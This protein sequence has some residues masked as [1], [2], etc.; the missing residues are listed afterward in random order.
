MI[1]Q[2]KDL[3]QSVSR[4]PW[5]VCLKQW[6]IGLLLMLSSF[7]VWNLATVF[8]FDYIVNVL[9]PD[10]GFGEPIWVI[11]PIGFMIISVPTG[12]VFLLGVLA[13]FRDLL[14]KEE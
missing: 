14:P 5:C 2:I 13:V 6:H 12:L 7:V 3:V 4:K 11:D 1:F 10:Q 8:L 9:H